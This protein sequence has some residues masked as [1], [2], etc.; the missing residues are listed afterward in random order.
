MRRRDCFILV[1]LLIVVSAPARGQFF[2]EYFITVGHNLRLP[3]NVGQKPI[4]FVSWDRDR[5]KK[6]LIGGENVGLSAFKTITP[7]L[8]IKTTI[9]VSRQLFW[10]EE[11]YFN[12]GPNLQDQLGRTTPATG[13]YYTSLTG[14]AHYMPKGKF[15]VG[16]GIGFEFLIASRTSFP[17]RPAI[18][19]KEYATISNHEFKRIMPVVPMEV[20]WKEERFLFNI[21]YEIGLLNR[22]RGDLKEY[23]QNIFQ[24]L[25]FEIGMKI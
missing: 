9:N 20:S 12:K 2:S 14:V 23:N 7:K 8:E 10:R 24:T 19:G 21:R 17:S 16:A 22:Y 15:S 13:E 5:E 1:T 6:L 11:V 25:A 3:G 18:T 4:P